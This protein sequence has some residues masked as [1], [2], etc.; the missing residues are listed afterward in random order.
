MREVRDT[1]LIGKTIMSIDAGAVNVLKL[2]F[3]DG[4]TLD[5]WAEQAIH[6]SDGDIPG[7]FTDAPVAA[8][9]VNTQPPCNHFGEVFLPDTCPGCAWLQKQSQG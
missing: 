3:T 1:D 5:L 4:T 2:T 6:T 8:Q 9:P 7:I